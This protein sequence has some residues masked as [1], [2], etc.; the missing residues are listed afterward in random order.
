MNHRSSL[1]LLLN[2]MKLRKADD[3]CA[4]LDFDSPKVLISADPETLPAIYPKLK[5]DFSHCF[6]VVTSDPYFI[7]VTQKGV[8]KGQSLSWIAEHAS[9]PLH[10]TIAFGD[11]LND[12]PM[13]KM[14][15]TGIAMGNAKEAVKAASDHITL[16]NDEEGI[17][18]YLSGIS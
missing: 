10:E 13:L 4:S 2:R 16:S 11:S 18:H 12:I 7:E 1:E 17:H 8:D 6:E 3:F 9:I 5:E 14:A 15:G